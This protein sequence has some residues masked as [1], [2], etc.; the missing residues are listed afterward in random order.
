MCAYIYGWCLESSKMYL[1]KQTLQPCHSLITSSLQIFLERIDMVINEIGL[2]NKTL[3]HWL[4]FV[5]VSQRYSSRYNFYFHCVRRWFPKINNCIFRS[6]VFVSIILSFSFVVSAQRSAIESS[7][8]PEGG[9]VVRS[10]TRRP[11]AVVEV[12]YTKVPKPIPRNDEEETIFGLRS[13]VLCLCGV[14]F[15]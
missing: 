9:P 5:P 6:F 12:W 10:R 7:D 14:G 4:T 15:S 2:I 13:I 1:Y 3:H 8:L 11:D